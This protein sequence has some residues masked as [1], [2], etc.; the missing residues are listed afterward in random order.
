MAYFLSD[1]E[2]RKKRFLED[3]EGLRVHLTLADAADRGIAIVDAFGGQAGLRS[4]YC[5]TSGAVSLSDAD[6]ARDAAWQEA[7]ERE[8]NAWRGP[9]SAPIPTSDTGRHVMDVMEMRDQALADRDRWQAEA[10]KRPFGDSGK[11]ARWAR[12]GA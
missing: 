3:G 6:K 8:A 5:F 11:L 7:R 2:L 12:S 4:G 9:A 10:W 1:E